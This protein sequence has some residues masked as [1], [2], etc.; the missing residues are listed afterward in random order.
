MFIA[1]EKRT[2]FNETKSTNQ[3][4]KMLTNFTT[5]KLRNHLL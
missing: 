5:L 2:I 1:S 3:Q 4:E